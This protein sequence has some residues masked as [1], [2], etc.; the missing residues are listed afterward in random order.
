MTFAYTLTLLIQ[1]VHDPTQDVENGKAFHA[2]AVCV[3]DST[4][5]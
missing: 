5:S 1:H 3:E 4:L 2:A